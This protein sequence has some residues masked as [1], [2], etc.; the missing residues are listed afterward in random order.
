MSTLLTPDAYSTILR[1]SCKILADFT[2]FEKNQILQTGIIKSFSGKSKRECYLECLSDSG[3]KSVNVQDNNGGGCE[4]SNKTDSD[5]GVTLM[6]KDGWTYW[7]TDPSKE[8]V[9]Y[10]CFIFS[11]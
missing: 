1:Q 10:L 7:S 2:I 6:Q 3:C 8:N 5:P 4:L 11:N 9:S